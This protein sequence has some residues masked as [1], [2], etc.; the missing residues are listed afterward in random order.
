MSERR[1]GADGETKSL[2][3]SHFGSVLVL[4]TGGTIGMKIN[5][6]GGIVHENI[7]VIR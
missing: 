1:T 3:D 6:D 5:E 4:Y 2:V 7:I